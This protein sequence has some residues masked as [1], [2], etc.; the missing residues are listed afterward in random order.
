MSDREQRCAAIAGRLSAEP[1]EQWEELF[2]AFHKEGFLVNEIALAIESNFAA[3]LIGFF[4][5]I[6]PRALRAGGCAV[7][8]KNIGDAL[9]DYEDIKGGHDA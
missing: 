7:M 2:V 8:L 6:E 5:N 9:Q 3:A 1:L 4:S